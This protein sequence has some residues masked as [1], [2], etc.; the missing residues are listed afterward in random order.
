[1]R[2][3]SSAIVLYLCMSAQADVL[4][5]IDGDTMEVKVYLW[6]GLTLEDQVRLL[7]PNTP[8]LRPKNMTKEQAEKEKAAALAAKAF[9]ENW[10]KAAAVQ[11]HVVIA[12]CGRDAF[13]RSLGDISDLKGDSLTDALLKS[14]HAKPWKR[15]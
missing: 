13:G 4:R 3:L 2:R 6:H 10:L 12:S 7:G 9:T 1:M 8:E 14:G 15:R 5:V 11:G